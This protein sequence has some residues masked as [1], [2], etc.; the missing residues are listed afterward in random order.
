MCSVLLIFLIFV[1]AFD[2]AKDSVPNW[3]SA[4]ALSSPAQCR[5][6]SLV[7]ASNRC[8]Y[9]GPNRPE[10]VGEAACQPPFAG[11][12]V[13]ETHQEARQDVT[14][15]LAVEVLEL[16]K[17]QQKDS[18]GMCTLPFSLV[19]RH[20]SS[21]SAPAA[22]VQRSCMGSLGSRR[23]SLEST[24]GSIQ[25][26]IEVIQPEK[27]HEGKRRKEQSQGQKDQEWRR[28]ESTSGQTTAISFCA[29]SGG[30][31]TMAIARG[32]NGQPAACFANCTDWSSKPGGGSHAQ[33]CVLR[34]QP[35]AARCERVHRKIRERD[36]QDGHKDA[37]F[38]YHSN[39]QGAEDPCRNSGGKEAAQGSLDCTYHGGH[40]NMAIPI[41][42]LPQATEYST[43]GCEQS[44]SRHRAVQNQHSAADHHCTRS[45]IGSHAFDAYGSR[46]GRCQSGSGQCGREVADAIA[47]GSQI[48]C[49]VIR[50]RVAD[51][52]RRIGCDG[53]SHQRR[54]GGKRAETTAIVRALWGITAHW[55]ASGQQDVVN[56]GGV[57]PVHSNGLHDAIATASL[58]DAYVVLPEPHAACHPLLTT[59]DSEA[60][61]HWQHS[62]QWEPNF[63][64]NFAAVL[65]AWK[66]RWQFLCEEFHEGL[67]HAPVL[68]AT[69]SP[70]EAFIHSPN[71]SDLIASN[72]AAPMFSRSE[73]RSCLRSEHCP[74]IIPKQKRVQFD[75]EISVH[76]GLEDN[77]Q[78][79]SIPIG[80]DD[81]KAWFDKPWKKKPIKSK[82]DHA[83]K[84]CAKELRTTDEYHNVPSRWF[85]QNEDIQEHDQND[86]ED[87]NHFLHEAP[88]ALQNLFDALQQEG[89]VT[90]P[91][92]HD[93]VF[94][95]TW[96]VHHLHFP[97][98]FHFRMIEL[99]GHWRFWHEEILGAWR[100]RIF[101]NELVIYDIVKPNPPRA[102]NIQQEILFDVILSQGLDAPRRAGLVTI[103]QRDDRAGRASFS[104]GV[105]LSERTSGHQTVQSAEQLHECNLHNCRIRH[106]REHIPFTMEPVH[107]MLD[108]DSFTVA[109]STQI[110]Q[111][112]VGNDVPNEPNI[113]DSLDHSDHD[114]QF[115]DDSVE[116]P[117]SI[118][119]TNDLLVGVHIHRLGHLQRHGRIRWDTVAHALIDAAAVVN[120]PP[121]DFVC[122]HHLQVE[123]ADQHDD[124]HSIIMQ[125]IHDIAPGSTEKLILVDVELHDPD[126]THDVPKAP[127]VSRAIYKVVPT[128]VR[129]HILHLT[130]TAAYC[131]WHEKD[132]LVFQNHALWHK[133]D[134]GPRQ[135]EHG[136]YIRVIVPPPPSPQ[137]EISKAIQA[138]HD[139]VATFECPAAYHVAI[140][141]LEAPTESSPSAHQGQHSRQAKSTEQDDD[142]DI[143]MMLGPH[144]RMRR[145][146]PEHDGMEDWLLDLGHIFSAQAI[147]ETIDGDAFLYVLT[148]Y[149]DHQRHPVCRSPRPLRLDPAAVAW[150]DEFR[151]LWRDLL[152]RRAIFSIHVVKP[153]PPQLRLQNYACHVLIEQHKPPGMS[154]GVLTTLLE[155]PNR[156]AIIQ[157][158]FSTPRFI[159]KQDL[160]DLMQVEHFCEGRRCTAYHNR[161]PVHLVVATEVE[162]GYS[163]RLH[164]EPSREQLPHAPQEQ[165][166][167]FDDLSLMQSSPAI[168]QTTGHAIDLPTG[169]QECAPYQPDIHAAVFQPGQIFISG[170]SEFVQDMYAQWTQ[171][172]F[173]WEDEATSADVITWFVDHRNGQER[174]LASRTVRLY[175][176]YFD[177][178]ALIERAWHDLFVEGLPHELHFVL[179][180]PPRLEHNTIGHVIL[181]QAPHEAWI[182]SLVT[183]FDSFI[184][185]RPDDF[186][187]LVI[188]T[189]EHV[190][191]GQVTQAC[192]YESDVNMHIPCQ[193]WID[194]H[195]LPP[196]IIWPGRSGHN[197]V[198]QVHRQVVVLPGL[199]QAAQGLNMLQL[200]AKKR[201]GA[202]TK[203]VLSLMELVPEPSQQPCLVPV[204][205]KQLNFN[206]DMPSEI[207]LPDGYGAQEI[208]H[209]LEKLGQNTHA[210]PMEGTGTAVIVPVDW[211]QEN[212]VTHLI[213]CP[214]QDTVAEFQDVILH[215]TRESI[216]ELLH[217]QTLHQFDFLRAVIISTRVLRKGLMQVCF[218]NNRPSLEDTGYHPKQRSPWPAPQPCIR[219][220]CVF[221]IDDIEHERPEHCLALGITHSELVAFFNSAHNVLCPWYRHLDLPDFVRQGIDGTATTEG[222]DIDV[223]GFD[224]LVIYTDGSSKPSERRKPP[225]K[226]AEQGTPDAWAF[227]VIGEK[228]STH[229]Q[230]G[231]L[232]LL[233]WQAQCVIYEDSCNAFAGSDQIGAEF[234]ERE[235]L[236]FAGLWRLSLNSNIPT[237]FRTDSTTTADQAFGISGFIS[238]HPTHELLR[239]TFQALQSCL[240]QSML[241]S[242]HVRGHTGDIWNELVDFLAKTEANRSHHL[243]RQQ[244]NVPK[245]KHVIPYLWMLF[246][247]S[248]GLP[249]FTAHGFDVHP[250][251]I[252]ADQPI[253]ESQQTRQDVVQEAKLQLSIATLNVGSLFVG[254]DGFGGKLSF[255]RCQMKSHALN[256]FGIQEARSPDGLSTAEDI[257]RLA[258][259][260]DRGKLGVELWISLVQ[261]YGYQKRTPLY[262]KKS[263]FQVLHNDPR[264]L[265][266]RLQ[267]T[268][269]DCFLIVLHAPQSG[270]P[271][272]IR[273]QWWQDTTALYDE[274]CQHL[275]SYVMLDANAKSGPTDEPTVFHH[276][277][278]VS[279]NTEFLLDFLRHAGL[280]LPSTTDVHQGDHTTWTSP[281][282]LSNHRIDYVA[283]PTLQLGRC[284]HSQVLHTMDTGNNHADHTACALQMQWTDRFSVKVDMNARCIHDRDK[285]ASS[286]QQLG[287]AQV[288]IGNLGL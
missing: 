190:Q 72:D 30:N 108:G 181:I 188:T 82:T 262:F 258:G 227:A 225:L 93:S 2:L 281:D 106:G 46:S 11:L 194:E 67:N 207:F 66:N 76:I 216:D 241:A 175:Q 280:C 182:S 203:H 251:N 204:K 44:Q 174:C 128:L 100:D 81:L 160:I 152:D 252:L 249:K 90:G 197:I 238:L 37:A 73:H 89:L 116:P 14:R 51:C 170:Q 195:H 131:D 239:G 92:I 222:A 122:F 217:M 27:S 120:Q 19:I 155:G 36:C 99:N 198:I 162:S 243:R 285:I 110:A 277:D 114:M 9:T 177:W 136:M 57:F 223:S 283:I 164:I 53:R 126:R 242:A 132:C 84:P 199:I 50:S 80:I 32:G 273:R 113:Q 129:Q 71:R 271:L 269:F 184:G 183:V 246:D 33:K 171:I 134:Q 142:I 250:P 5:Q 167:H 70:S 259:G 230:P 255:L 75:S 95:R 6:A 218:R 40:Q 215:C 74:K 228:Y 31:A 119:S 16:P 213:Y 187:R 211:K 253:S 121:T 206:P 237:V 169:V 25:I 149:I 260:A 185:S 229:D 63:Q 28:K 266:V 172:A 143:P 97:Q 161:E 193:V 101:P 52:T 115:D 267:N 272:P 21:N 144:V 22:D 278:V 55:F 111:T 39:G 49:R 263:H 127:A 234:S 205:L 24:E 224:R 265:F 247:R 130:H 54:R 35:D 62:I 256:I 103:L 69:P 20:A 168:S 220:Q 153:R 157:G 48:L 240:G 118:A 233:G 257:L 236:L 232:T 276:D 140:A 173:S 158:A 231:S 17:D 47:I 154:A 42:G 274:L 91:R 104:V 43:R 286:W 139:A 61:L 58:A 288:H 123:P 4:Q 282:G 23:R 85:Q 8:S 29:I 117:P 96:F 287:A 98:C 275:P 147:T 186:S 151:H 159:R 34:E 264:R 163:V 226:V 86:P 79:A 196:G 146:R 1:I 105:S 64:N 219:H 59:H 138:F 10:E 124:C 88:D 145:L 41:A 68:P 109:I 202:R 141:S 284:T 268:H 13:F 192:G 235:A 244:L 137:W 18:S 112:P 176:N 12:P 221:L 189:H 261:P 38:S 179:P 45:L 254:P 209:E 83:T 102:V 212:D 87:A 60:L 166:S 178:E 200:S 7:S 107:D 150:I 214:V 191:H 26:P 78:M 279:G 270:Q 248:A 201:S 77:L 156:D 180:H 65:G 3:I 210:Y 15:T 148:W 125:H 165:Q 135:I 245:L 208:E 56:A 133:Q 94:I